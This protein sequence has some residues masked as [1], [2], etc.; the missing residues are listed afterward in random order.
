MTL[1]LIV[2][3]LF[4]QDALERSALICRQSRVRKRVLVNDGKGCSTI[5]ANCLRHFPMVTWHLFPNSNCLVLAHLMLLFP[6]AARI[7]VV[8]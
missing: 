4:T 8:S 3:V 7:P 1:E 6:P 5:G 2:N